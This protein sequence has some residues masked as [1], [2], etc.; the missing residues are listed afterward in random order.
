MLTRVDDTRVLNLLPLFDKPGGA[1]L[2]ASELI[3]HQR[4]HYKAQGVLVGLAEKGLVQENF[5]VTFCENVKWKFGY[6]KVFLRLQKWAKIGNFNVGISHLP[7]ANFMNF[8]LSLVLKNYIPVMVVHTTNH[9]WNGLIGKLLLRLAYSKHGCVAISTGVANSILDAYGRVNIQVLSN[10]IS[11]IFFEVKQS[12]KGSKETIANRDINLVTV[13]RLIPQKNYSFMLEALYLL[14]KNYKLTIVGQGNSDLILD[15]VNRLHLDNRVT[16]I[17]GL[18]EL[19]VRNILQ[20]SDIFLMTSDSEGEPRA[21]IEAA[22]QDLPVCVRNTSGLAETA[23]KVGG[24]ILASEDTPGA[25]AKF[26]QEISDNALKNT[27][28]RE[29]WMDEYLPRE[30]CH[31]YCELIDDLLTTKIQMSK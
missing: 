22:L 25:F 27:I 17:G 9:D 3:V 1:E 30:A 24:Y 31:R 8:L 13:G 28:M 16:I 26:I 6:I 23:K 19:E 12:G 2:V 10:P 21:V 18:K 29:A 14:P 4:L 5:D 11:S 20:A 15:L 7:I